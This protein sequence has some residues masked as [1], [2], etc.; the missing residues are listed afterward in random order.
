MRP[1][2]LLCSIPTAPNRTAVQT[3]RRPTEGPSP[4][5][6]HRHRGRRTTTQLAITHLTSVPGGPTIPSD[7]NRA[8]PPVQR[9][10][11]IALHPTAHQ[12][13]RSSA[14][15]QRHR[16]RP[17]Q[18]RR[19]T[20]NAPRHPRRVA[21]YPLSGPPLSA[22][23]HNRR[24]RRFLHLPNLS[25]ARDRARTNR[26]RP[27]TPKPRLPHHS[28]ANPAA[29]PF[30]RVTPDRGA[31]RSPPSAGNSPTSSSFAPCSVPGVA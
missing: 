25:F 26:S 23:D 9:L 18:R 13:G 28:R 19:Q 24:N 10:L 22:T 12:R 5:W 8:P 31:G 2:F 17:D 11:A 4:R 21:P 30:F 20:F 16:F 3:P 1:A 14:G 7:K 15:T 29:P 6:L 27:S